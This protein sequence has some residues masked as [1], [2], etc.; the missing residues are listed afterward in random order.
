MFVTRCSTTT[1]FVLNKSITDSSTVRFQMSYYDRYECLVEQ[2]IL[3]SG[4]K[5]QL[6]IEHNDDGCKENKCGRFTWADS[7][8]TYF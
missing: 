4:F 5:A 7:I 3:Y 8:L 1:D 6:F 2:R